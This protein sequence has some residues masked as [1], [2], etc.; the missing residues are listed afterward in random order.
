MKIAA[1]SPLVVG[2]DVGYRNLAICALRKGEPVPQLWQVSDI[3]GNMKPTR[4]TLFDAM[5]RWCETHRELL[6]AADLIVL[7]TQRKAL[8][9]NLNTVVMTLYPKK[10]RE[11][12]PF[13]LCA[14]YMLPRSRAEKKKATIERVKEAFGVAALPT[15]QAKQDDL[16][17]A[18]L[19]CLWGHQNLH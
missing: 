10:T 11:L 4:Q 12:H 6:V 5:M 18:A 9:Q 14:A 1:A 19:F 16:A 3:L 17:D 7:E 13:T 2:I 8:Y 15:T